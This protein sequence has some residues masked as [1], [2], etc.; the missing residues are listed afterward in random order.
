MR[1]KRKIAV[2]GLIASFANYL[3]SNEEKIFMIFDYEKR[4]PINQIE[5]EIQRKEL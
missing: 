1:V 4:R 5:A 3:I 2:T